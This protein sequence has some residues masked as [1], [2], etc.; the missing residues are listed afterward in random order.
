MTQENLDEET[1]PTVGE[2]IDSY[3]KK[4]RDETESSVCFIGTIGEPSGFSVAGDTEIMTLLPAMLRHMAN[5]IDAE[6]QGGK[7]EQ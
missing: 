2:I 1:K 7:N 4:V 5:E 6:M 3:C